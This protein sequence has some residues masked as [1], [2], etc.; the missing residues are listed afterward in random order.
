M[1]EPPKALSTNCKNSNKF[2]DNNNGQSA[3]NQ[4]IIN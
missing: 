3:G 4:I 2:K 1:L